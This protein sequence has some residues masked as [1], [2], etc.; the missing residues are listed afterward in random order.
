MGTN[1][2]AAVGFNIFRVVRVV[3]NVPIDVRVFLRVVV[4]VELVGMTRFLVETVLTTVGIGVDVEDVVED[5]VEVDVVDVDV[6]VD[7]DVG[8]VDV[9]DVVDVTDGVEGDVHVDVSSDDD[10]VDVGANF[11]TTQRGQ[12]GKN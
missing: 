11:M 12:I 1:A 7:V 4:L 10:S 9:E 5:G 3:F 6:D 2:D 8:V